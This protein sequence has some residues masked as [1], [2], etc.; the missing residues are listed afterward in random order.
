[1]QFMLEVPEPPKPPPSPTPWDKLDEATHI[2]ALEILARLI[3]RMIAAGQVRGRPMS[4]HAKVTANHLSRAAVVYLRQSSP[5]LV[6]NSPESTDRHYTLVHK[7]AG[8]GWPA[9]RRL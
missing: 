6:E 8:L 4:E 3:A 5:A 1:M 9:E 7:A 2:A